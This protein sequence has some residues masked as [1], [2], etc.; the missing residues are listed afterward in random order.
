MRAHAQPDFDH[1]FDLA[2][3]RLRLEAHLDQDGR[4]IP[5]K[6]ADNVLVATW[7]LT[8]FG[9]QR[10]TPS[11]IQYMADVIRRFDVVALQ[12]IADDLED[13][14][15]LFS[16]LPAGWD[17]LFT[18]IG[19]NAERLAYVWDARRVLLTGLAGELAMRAHERH[20]V[21]VEDVEVEGGFPGFNRNPYMLGFESGE[22]EFYLVNVH[23]YW[24]NRDL[25]VLETQ[26]LG[27]WAETRMGR[28]H[29]PH[30]DIILIGDFNMPRA[31]AGDP[32]YDTLVANGLRVP[33]HETNLVGTNLAGDNDY[34]QVAFFPG[35]TSE[36]FTGRMGVVDFDGAVVPD[37]W[38]QN[39]TGFFQYVRYYLADHR[40][41]WAEFRR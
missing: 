20:R 9:L 35:R 3:E 21:V 40:P 16:A 19:G 38:Q 36:D 24:S 41:L 12:E 23:L 26:A 13:F 6:A 10:R 4:R 7:N 15:A 11:H 32:I 34:D 5:G 33:D 31:R 28:Q 29:P 8:N 18:D 14:Y 30:N 17:Y 25:R 1:P 27:K 37:L 39:E 22:F 2:A